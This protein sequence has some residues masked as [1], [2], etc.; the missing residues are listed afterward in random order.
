MAPREGDDTKV[1]GDAT[2]TTPNKP[3]E[4]GVQSGSISGVSIGFAD[5]SYTVPIK[6]KNKADGK[7]LKILHS[8][9]GSFVPGR[10][11]AIMGPS[12]KYDKNERIGQ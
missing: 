6:P 9:S 4:S 5:L 10:M 11:S 7:Y 2:G 8:I 3:L 12:G 1:A